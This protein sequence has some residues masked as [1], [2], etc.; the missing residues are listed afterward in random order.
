MPAF[1]LEVVTPERVAYSGQVASLQAPGS[2]GGFGVLA[3]HIPLLTS[4]Q[5]GRL[6]FVEEDG[7]EVQMAISGGFV[8][9]GRE[10]VAVLAETAERVEEID[11]ARAEAARQRAEERLARAREERV[12]VARAEAALARAINRI[13]IGS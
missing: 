10:Q 11:V 5:I 3:G 13:R 7:N 2:E 1:A 12:D 9:V 8:E 6:R 4:L